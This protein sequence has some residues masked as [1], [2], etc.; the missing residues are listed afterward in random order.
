MQDWFEME[1]GSIIFFDKVIGT[2]VI[3]EKYINETGEFYGKR[4]R[5][6]IKVDKTTAYG[7]LLYYPEMDRFTKEFKEWLPNRNKTM[8][9]EVT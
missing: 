2:H 1:D 9:E 6:D 4:L 3:P 8:S 7:R 5:V